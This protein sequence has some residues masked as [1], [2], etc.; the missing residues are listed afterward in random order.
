MNEI[1]VEEM[2]RA[3]VIVS[4]PAYVAEAALDVDEV[5]PDS[6]APLV[7]GN[8]PIVT[9]PTSED[10][11]VAEDKVEDKNEDDDMED[12]SKILWEV[13]D[14][15]EELH[16]E[17]KD[18]LS[19]T[20]GGAS[21]Q[22]P[23]VD[24]HTDVW[25]TGRAWEREYNLHPESTRDDISARLYNQVADMLQIMQE[26]VN[27]QTWN[28]GDKDLIDGLANILVMHFRLGRLTEKKLKDQANGPIM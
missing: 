4:N 8:A 27:Q 25:D 14:N 3:S 23:L 24:P 21:I 19:P 10:G 12:L 5:D 22:Q 11:L 16:K 7:S 2:N 13:L 20:P 18:L 15:L 28:K 1:L 17:V 9:A 26:H 6:L